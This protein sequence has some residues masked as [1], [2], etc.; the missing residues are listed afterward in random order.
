MEQGRA[1][2]R[3]GTLTDC[4][5]RQRRGPGTSEAVAEE[6]RCTVERRSDLTYTEFIQQYVRPPVLA[7]PSSPGNGS[8]SSAN[9]DGAVTCL[10]ALRDQASSGRLV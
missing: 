10:P 6:E 5:C 1:S 2:G 9:L 8:R 4:A 3:L 7:T